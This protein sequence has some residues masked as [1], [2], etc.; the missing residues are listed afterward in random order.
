LT[1]SPRIVT[2]ISVTFTGTYRTRQGTDGGMTSAVKDEQAL[3]LRGLFRDVQRGALRGIA[4][5]KAPL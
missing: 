2:F 1:Q 4:L 5:L 3:E